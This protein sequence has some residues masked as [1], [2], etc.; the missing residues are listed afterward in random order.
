[1]FLADIAYSSSLQSFKL[2]AIDILQR[3]KDVIGLEIIRSVERKAAQNDVIV[4]VQSTCVSTAV[5]Q[6]PTH[7]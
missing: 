1:M 4:E 6:Q 2:L 3:S 7:A 5:R